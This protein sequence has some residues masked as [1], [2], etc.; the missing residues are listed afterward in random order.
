MVATMSS[1]LSALSLS[2]GVEDLMGPGAAARAVAC[3]QIRPDRFD[4]DVRP[5][6]P[7]SGCFSGEIE[8]ENGEGAIRSCAAER[9]L[10][11]L[12]DTIRIDIAEGGASV[13]SISQGL[14]MLQ[15]RGGGLS[16]TVQLDAELTALVVQVDRCGE[17]HTG[18]IAVA[19]L[20]HSGRIGGVDGRRAE[21]KH[22]R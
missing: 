18:A 22:G 14:R 1:V 11:D 13:W 3:D 20:F 5:L 2:G 10:H 7:A 8:F 12:D 6:E 4:L 19:L 9:S 17:L 15:D 21:H 16:W